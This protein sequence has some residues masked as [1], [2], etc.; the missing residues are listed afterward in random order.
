MTF[1][2][3]PVGTA[4]PG[5]IERAL[6]RIV[7]DAVAQAQ[8]A[9]SNVQTEWTLRQAL[10]NSRIWLAYHQAIAEVF[11]RALRKAAVHAFNLTGEHSPKTGAAIGRAT[12]HG[13]VQIIEW[14]KRKAL[15]STTFG[16]HDPLLDQLTAALYKIRDV[17]VDD[18]IHGMV[19]GTP[20]KK[21]VAPPAGPTI[22][23]SPNAVQ[24]TVYGDRNQL[25]VQQQA[26]PL[27]AAIDDMLASNDFRQL[28]AEQQTA[29]RDHADAVRGELTK[30]NPDISTAKRWTDR[31][32]KLARDFG[33]AVA[34]HAL[35]KIVL[36]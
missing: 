10:G 25:S 15:A 2:A 24:Q 19:G 30:P 20:L 33:L 22:I 16:R 27:L 26:V 6:C 11:Q 32:V 4:D 9:V 13:V 5:Y 36:G 29:I 35:S 17:V 23:N 12:E 34:A 1:S 18:F 31:L 14:M 8:V 28:D 7:D 3:A 21:P